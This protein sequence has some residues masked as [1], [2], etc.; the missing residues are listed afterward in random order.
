M[1]QARL[2]PIYSHA[3]HSVNQRAASSNEAALLSAGKM[4]ESEVDVA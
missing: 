4:A 3:R 2:A 1:G